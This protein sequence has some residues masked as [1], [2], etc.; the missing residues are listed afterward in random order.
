MTVESLRATLV[1]FREANHFQVLGLVPGAEAARIK[2]AYFQLAK[3]YHPDATRDGESAESRQLRADVFARIG[4]AWAALEDDTRRAAYVQELESGGS[5]EVDISVI[6][7]SEEIFRTV[8]PLV[9]SRSYPEALKRVNEAI[10]LYADEPEYGVWKAW[11]EFLLAP[12]GQKKAQRAAGERVIE[13]ALKQSP[14]CKPA[15]RFLSLMAKL[16]GDAAAAERQ[17]KR[18][19]AE[20][21]DDPELQQDLRYLKK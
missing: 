20:L 14:K 4:A 3:V 13:A 17:L 19:L 21:P 16:T 11:I 5:A 12:E 8:E 18:G 9:K 7:R 10:S 1:Q 6:F 2:S 15:Y